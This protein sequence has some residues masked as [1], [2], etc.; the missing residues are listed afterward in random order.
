[1]F[2]SEVAIATVPDTSLISY[3]KNNI[4]NKISCNDLSPENADK[5][6]SLIK[7]IFSENTVY[8]NFD[9][10]T[11]SSFKIEFK[12]YGDNRKKC[13]LTFNFRTRS[14]EFAL[15]QADKDSHHP[16]DFEFSDMWI[17]QTK[18]QEKISDTINKGLE[19]AKET[20]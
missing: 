8:W 18:F 19:L 10:E 2:N 4:L 9:S 17:D 11:D 14:L 15:S 7:E 3:L 5:V 12:K 6:F 20:Y 1:M 16:I 13:F